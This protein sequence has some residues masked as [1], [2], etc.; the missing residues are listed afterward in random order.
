MRA[1]IP[2]FFLNMCPHNH[3]L[4]GAFQIFSAHISLTLQSPLRAAERG[5]MVRKFEMHPICRIR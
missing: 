3:D 5:E 4:P 1:K 2:D